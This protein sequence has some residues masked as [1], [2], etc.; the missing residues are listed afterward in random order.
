MESQLFLVEVTEK[1]S[2]LAPVRQTAVRHQRRSQPWMYIS[3]SYFWWNKNNFRWRWRLNP[4]LENFQTNS[5]H[6]SLTE[7]TQKPCLA[8]I[9]INK[10]NSQAVSASGD[11]SCI[12]WD[13]KNHTRL[14]CLFES[15]AFKQALLNTE[16]YQIL[17]AGSD[18][19]VTYWEKYDG[20]IIRSVEAS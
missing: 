2:F 3:H 19:K 5:S 11:G 7:R 13:L 4:N 18:R 16:E 15:T 10:D 8:L 14:L 12:I 6:G 1:S 17:T 20:T 9:Q